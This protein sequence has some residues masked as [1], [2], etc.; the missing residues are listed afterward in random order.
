MYQKI[1]IIGNIGNDAIV[2]DLPSTQVIQFNV[3][4]SES[5]TNKATNEKVTKTTWF[6]C[7]SFT[8]NVAVAPYLKKGTQVM[9]E[10]KA[11]NRAYINDRN[12]IIVVNG[13]KVDSIK[14]LGAKN[15]ENSQPA[16]PHAG[17]EF[18]NMKKEE[19]KKDKFGSQA[20][21]SFDEEAEDDPLP[22]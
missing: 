22:F 6:Q 10:G 7:Q 4:T 16:K 19:P 12:E 21:P 1:L 17:D 14:L 8:N 9:V 2:K 13:I 5:W 20:D 15:S 11:D 18:L 3:A